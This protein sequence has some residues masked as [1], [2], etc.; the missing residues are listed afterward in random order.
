[1][2]YISERE[3]NVKEAAERY[4]QA[5]LYSFQR[6]PNIGVHFVCILCAFLC[7]FCM[8]FVCICVHLC[9]FYMHFVCILCAFCVHFVC[10]LC[11]FLCILCAFLCILCAFCVH[12]CAFCIHF[13]CIGYRLAFNYLK[14]HSYVKSMQ[15]CYKVLEGYPQYPRMQK[16]ILD[17]AKQSLKP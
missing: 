1:M 5:W 10:I 6:D 3:H 15:V 9:A 2:G 14:L 16:E 8:H 13:L 7:A 11:A 17:K 12:F 4:E